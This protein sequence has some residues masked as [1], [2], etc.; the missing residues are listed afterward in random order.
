M[1]VKLLKQQ[2]DKMDSLLVE[3]QENK[4]V[5]LKSERKRGGKKHK[6][7]GKKAGDATSVVD[8]IR[9]EMPTEEEILEKNLKF[10]RKLSTKP[11]EEGVE[12]S[13]KTRQWKQLEVKRETSEATG[14]K[15]REMALKTILPGFKTRAERKS[16]IEEQEEEEEGLAGFSC[17]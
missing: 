15:A 8:Q 6:K 2:L 1:S 5:F 13:K 17:L 10:Y 3:K 12:G 16:K 7:K 14:V 11:A 9:K 4:K